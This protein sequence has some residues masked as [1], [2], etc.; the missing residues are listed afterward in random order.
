MT[1]VLLPSSGPESWKKLLADPELH[2]KTGYS[3]RALAHAWEANDSLPLEIAALLRSYTRFTGSQPEL[4][5]AFPEWKVPLPGGRR[6]SQNDVFALVRVGETTL[7]L[8]VEGKVSEPFGPS[9]DEWLATPTAGRRKR[10][11]FLCDLLG[12][13]VQAIAHLRYQLLHRTASAIIERRRFGMDTAAMFVHSFSQT[14]E[15]FDDFATFLKALG[16]KAEVG[17]VVQTTISFGDELILGWAK[18]DAVFL[19]A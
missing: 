7:S 2:W 18:G 4:L 1:R 10:L 8:A 3:A 15:W 14:N 6:K 17:S 9:V 12:L 13:D 19:E 11:R 16:L 5:A